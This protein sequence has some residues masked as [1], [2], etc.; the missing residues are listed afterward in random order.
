M[1]NPYR[2]WQDAVHQK[3]AGKM[4]G[5][6]PA[7][8]VLGPNPGP[9]IAD[10]YAVWRFGGSPKEKRCSSTSVSESGGG[11]ERKPQ[12]LTVIGRK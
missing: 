2:D 10:L 7:D 5:G 4:A 12:I 6:G 1:R 8:K 9:E 11:G 3:E